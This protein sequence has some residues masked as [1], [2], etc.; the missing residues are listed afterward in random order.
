MK[1][2][3]FEELKDAAASQ[4]DA[5][6]GDFGRLVKRI[7]LG[8]ITP[9]EKRAVRTHLRQ[10]KPGHHPTSTRIDVRRTLIAKMVDAAEQDGVPT[11]AAVAYAMEWFKAGRS[12]VYAARAEYRASCKP[13]T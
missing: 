7:R 1:R 11:E 12:T 2:P 9:A 13:W 3:R 4:V 8:E 10:R 6:D 5:L